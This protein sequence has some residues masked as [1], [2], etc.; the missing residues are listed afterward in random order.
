[1]FPIQKLSNPDSRNKIANSIDLCFGYITI[2]E[3]NFNTK[4]KVKNY[5]TI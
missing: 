2:S 3:S 5:I 1:M 4:K